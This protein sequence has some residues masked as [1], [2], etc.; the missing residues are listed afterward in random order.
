[1][2]L[3][4][5]NFYETIDVFR[6]LPE[7]INSA[8]GATFR[9]AYGHEEARIEKNIVYIFRSER[10]IPRLKGESDIVYIGQTKGT[11]GQRYLSSAA[12]HASSKANKMK[13]EHIVNYY[14]DIRITVA[15]YTQFGDSL[16]KAE[17]QLLWWYFQNHCEYPPVNYTKT[18]VRNDVVFLDEL[19]FT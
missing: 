15:S 9:R 12:L 4:A 13:F 11:F 19:R 16:L 2:I 10:P 14:G 1:M 3:T 8:D 5:E 18:K 7:R 17:G 6:Q